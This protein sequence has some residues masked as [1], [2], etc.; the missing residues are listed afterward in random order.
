MWY[1]T[2]FHISSKGLF[3]LV[4]FLRTSLFLSYCDYWDHRKTHST[5]NIRA[6]IGLFSLS[7]LSSVLRW[8]WPIRTSGTCGWKG[9][10][11]IQL[12]PLFYRHKY[13]HTRRLGRCVLRTVTERAGDGR[14]REAAPFPSPHSFEMLMTPLPSSSS[15]CSLLF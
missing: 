3:S 6:Q 2:V 4:C 11:L 14:E 10:P 9:L 1:D 7:G 8:A 13:T 12:T 5:M 15:L